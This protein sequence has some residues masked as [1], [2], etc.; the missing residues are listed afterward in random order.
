MNKTAIIYLSPYDILRPRTNQVSDVRFCEGFAQNGCEV[1]L[2]VPTVERADNILPGEIAQVYGLEQALNYHFLDTQ[3]KADVSGKRNLAKVGWL[4]TKKALAL[5]R[6]LRGSNITII[7]RNAPLLQLLLLWKKWLP[8]LKGVQIIHWAHEYKS[9]KSYRRIYS[10]CDGILATNSSIIHDMCAAT[11]I[12]TNKTCVK[13]G[14]AH[15]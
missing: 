3:F 1:H 13:I 11:G 8:G 14:R 7:S 9:R 2:I 15:V 6:S 5:V 10:L 12:P 4:A